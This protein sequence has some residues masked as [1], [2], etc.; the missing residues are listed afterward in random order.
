MKKHLRFALTLVLVIGLALS[1]AALVS[2]A[3]EDSKTFEGTATGAVDVT[4]DVEYQA[5]TDNSADIA[6]GKDGTKVYSVTM[7]WDTDGK[8]TY[9]AGKTTY[10]WN[11]ND[12]KY[13]SEVSNKGWTVSGAKVLFTVKNRSNAEVSVKCADPQPISGVTITG[14]YDNAQVTLPSAATGGIDGVGKEQSATAVYTISGVSGELGS[15]VTNIASITVTVT[16]Q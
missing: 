16:G 7:E 1:A 4:V 12:L 8:I 10:S 15:A 11:K 3:D 6:A 9:N 13:D 14:S 5:P 2:L